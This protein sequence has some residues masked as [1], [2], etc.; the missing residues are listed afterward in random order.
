MV[1]VP[2]PA[3]RNVLSSLAVWLEAYS[4]PKAE[5]RINRRVFTVQGRHSGGGAG[6]KWRDGVGTELDDIEI[7]ELP[8]R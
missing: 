6:L 8:E 3:V 4:L 2:E 7:S 1:S 5:L